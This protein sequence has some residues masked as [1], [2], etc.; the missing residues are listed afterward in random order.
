LLSPFFFIFAAL[1]ALF[2]VSPLMP[3][4]HS[5]RRFR[6]AFAPRQILSRQFH[7]RLLL[8]SPLTPP[9]AATTSFR[10]FSLLRQI[11]AIFTLSPLSA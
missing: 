4:R 7:F 8:I 9:P 6:H 5:F 10:R 1:P 2:S 3:S 11:S